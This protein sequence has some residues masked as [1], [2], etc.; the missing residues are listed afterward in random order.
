MHLMSRIL[1]YG[2]I[3]VAALMSASLPAYASAAEAWIQTP[4]VENR[5]TNLTPTSWS[6]FSHYTGGVYTDASGIV[7]TAEVTLANAAVLRTSG[8]SGAGG[9]WD[10]SWSITNEGSGDFTRFAAIAGGLPHFLRDVLRTGETEFESATVMGPIIL[11]QW[12]G[13]WGSTLTGSGGAVY[14]LAASVPEPG[15]MALL[16]MA[17]LVMTGF[18]GG[19]PAAAARSRALSRR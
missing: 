16:G 11:A 5:Q 12:N 2:S 3:A 19:V 9:L 1:M 6:V 7:R 8:A 18:T 17:F 4:H 10:V 15:T 14:F 13:Q